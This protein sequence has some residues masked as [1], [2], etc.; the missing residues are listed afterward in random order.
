[1]LSPA[2]K[3]MLLRK[4]KT[5]YSPLDL[6]STTYLDARI[7][8]SIT[9]GTGVS[10]WTSQSGNVNY[11]EGTGSAQAAYNLTGLDGNPAVVF[12]GVNDRLTATRTCGVFTRIFLVKTAASGFLFG[13][14]NDYIWTGSGSTFEVSRGAGFI[15]GKNIAGGWLNNNKAKIVIWRFDGTHAGNQVLVNGV[16]KTTTNTLV[17]NPGTATVT[18]TAGLMTRGGTGTGYLSGALSYFRD[19]GYVLTQD[20]ID[21]EVKFILSNFLPTAKL[22][23]NGLPILDANQDLT[24]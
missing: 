8:S 16:L 19:F 17:A 12:D 10:Q 4:K 18:A 3:F 2:Q 1:M 13:L 11:T 14:V 24:Y 15:S 6:P 21:N 22:N 23:S 5:G 20:Q 7:G 9:I